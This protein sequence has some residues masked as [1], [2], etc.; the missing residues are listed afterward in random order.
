MMKKI[1]ILLL[2]CASLTSCVSKKKFAELQKQYSTSQSHGDDMQKSL[3]EA[4]VRL[5]NCNSENEAL[6]NQLA[7]L[8]ESSKLLASNLFDEKKK[9]TSLNENINLLK[10]NV[11][12]L[13]KNNDNLFDRLADLSVVSKTGAE[14]IKKSLE[15]I[16]SQGKYIQNLN[17]SMQ[18]KDSL[19]L[20]LVMNLKRSLADVNDK[21]VTVEVKKGVVYISISDKMLFQSGEF[22]I[23][24]EAET[25]LGKIAKVL[26]DHT[27]LDIL[28]EGHTDNEPISKP[29]SYISD[30]WDLSVKRATSVV[31]SLQTRFGV[32]PARMTAGG[33]GEFTP[34]TTNDTPDNKKL[35]RRTEIILL[36][37][38]DQFF[39]L[40]EPEKK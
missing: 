27:E 3:D 29:T 37:K 26:N 36:P 20:A 32:N 34:K 14:N 6:K 35:N 31:R 25:V 19:N 9:V 10:E 1:S 40:M 28:V 30:N 21:D 24:A 13:K 7:S 17:G 12:F 39:Q 18:R 2:I 23:G 38:L 11:D 16:N 15:A 5:N 33:R 4:K 8:D 22:S